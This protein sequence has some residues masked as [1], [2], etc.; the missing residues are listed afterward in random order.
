MNEET[1][2]QP[3]V[4]APELSL[5]NTGPQ[6]TVGVRFHNMEHLSLLNRCLCCIA[7]QEGVNVHLL[8]ALQ[9]F[10]ADQVAQ[11]EALTTRAFTGSDFG[12]ELIN[13]PNPN[14][15]DLR[16]ALLNAIVER[17]YERDATDYLVFID[18]DDI[19]FQFAL[20]TLIEPLQ[21]GAFAL[22]Y[23][24]I[25]C[26]D[27]FYDAGQTYLCDI[28]DVFQIKHKTKRDLMQDNFLPLHSYMF[29]TSRIEPKLLHYDENLV[30]LED[31]DVL[32]S[33]ARRYPFAGLHRGQLIGLYNFYSSLGGK[34]NTSRNVFLPME[35]EAVE[36]VWHQARR[37]VIARHG[38]APW[39][40]FAGE[41]WIL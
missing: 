7:A 25:H 38:G 31:Y 37:T 35:D 6:V 1:I 26:A 28:R 8:L 11:V 21:F 19:W 14:N 32:L 4:A 12:F 27:V 29:Q 20:R 30:R 22:S 10:T 23:A 41:E 39:H 40:E 16:S 15:K 13:M 18:Y 34:M 17:H 9:D 3:S 36:E 33:I 5:G 24:D 2:I